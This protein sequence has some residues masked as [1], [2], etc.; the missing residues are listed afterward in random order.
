MNPARPDIPR[1]RPGLEIFRTGPREFLLH[2]PVTGAQVQLGAEER[3]LIHALGRAESLDEI[4][5]AFEDRFRSRLPRERLLEFL[6]QARRMGLTLDGDESPAATRDLHAPP[7]A[8]KPAVADD[9]R[10]LSR[11]DKGANLNLAFD[12]LVVFFGWI[13]HPISIAPVSA[14]GL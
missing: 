10:P 3:F 9:P 6:G 8:P 5:W 13:L 2:D 11:A 4:L 12:L 1:L 14:M 7:P